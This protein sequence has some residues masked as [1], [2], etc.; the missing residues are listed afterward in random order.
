MIRLSTKLFM[1]WNIFMAK[2]N[3]NLIKINKTPQTLKAR[4]KKVSLFILHVINF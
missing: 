1:D 2:T 3:L 4:H